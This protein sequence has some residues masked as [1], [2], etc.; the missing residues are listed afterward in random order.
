MF[1]HKLHTEFPSSA[2]NGY[3]AIEMSTK[4]PTNAGPQA[5]RLKGIESVEL[6]ISLESTRARFEKGY[7]GALERDPNYCKYY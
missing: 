3:W 7:V 1:T 4:I 2:Q 5:K 6:I